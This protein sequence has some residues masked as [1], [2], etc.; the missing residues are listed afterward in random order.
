[1]IKIQKLI[2][3]IKEMRLPMDFLAEEETEFLNAVNC[4]ICGK[5]L[6][7]DRVRDHDH[8]AGG[9]I[10]FFILFTHYFIVMFLNFI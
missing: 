4:H 9:E 6:N 8:M 3:L 1:M 7:N 5:A 2:T 10:F